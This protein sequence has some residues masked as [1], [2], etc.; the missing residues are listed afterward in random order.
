MNEAEPTPVRSA[1]KGAWRGEQQSGD[2]RCTLTFHPSG[3]VQGAG[4][5]RHGAFRIDGALTGDAIA[6]TKR[7]GQH[8]VD[9]TGTLDQAAGT[10]RGTWTIGIARVTE[11]GTFSLKRV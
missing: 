9:Y 11:R 5:D 8:F 6:F 2:M 3:K 7:Y 1:W 10:M 4:A